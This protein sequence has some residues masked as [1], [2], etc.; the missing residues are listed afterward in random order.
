MSTGQ[1][2]YGGVPGWSVDPAYVVTRHWHHIFMCH[3][4]HVEHIWKQCNLNATYINER[5]RE[6]N[7]AKQAHTVIDTKGIW[8]H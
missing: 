6:R 2:G 4:H 3:K 7:T 5:E 1:F 8:T